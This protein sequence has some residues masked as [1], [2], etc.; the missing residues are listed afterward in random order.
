MSRAL[1]AMALE[2]G[3]EC[4]VWPPSGHLNEFIRM[5]GDVRIWQ[6]RSLSAQL[7]IPTLIGHSVQALKSP[8]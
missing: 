8:T 7:L 4:P 6:L 5:S 1:G 3:T 2:D